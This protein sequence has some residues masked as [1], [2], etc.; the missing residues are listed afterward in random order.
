M[1]LTNRAASVAACFFVVVHPSMVLAEVSDKVPSPEFSWAVGL[2]AGIL[3]LFTA[4]LKPWLATICVT[5]AAIWFISLFSEIHSPDVGPQLK[6]E[7]GSSYY[8][9]A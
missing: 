6:L 5:P 7:Q 2:A 3:S 4:R 1:R 8:L 9:Q